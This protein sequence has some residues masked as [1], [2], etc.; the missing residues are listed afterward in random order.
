MASIF[1][2]QLAHR[3]PVQ[4]TWWRRTIFPIWSAPPR[5]APILDLAIQPRRTSGPDRRRWLPATTTTTAGIRPR[6]RAI[7]TWRRRSR[8]CHRYMRRSRLG[9]LLARWLTT[10]PL[11]RRQSGCSATPGDKPDDLLG[12]LCCDRHRLRRRRWI[13][14][15]QC[16]RFARPRRCRQGRHGRT[17]SWGSVAVTGLTQVRTRR[18]C[19]ATAVG[20]LSRS[21]RHVRAKSAGSA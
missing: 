12:A 1:A 3:A 15:L 18:R 10:P 8:R 16:S 4:A 14:D 2:E 17:R 9:C 7:R 5:P 13:D 20:R 21:S 6:R 19:R 11:P